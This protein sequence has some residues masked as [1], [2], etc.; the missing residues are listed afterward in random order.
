MLSCGDEP[1]APVQPKVE[2]PR[3]EPV[4]KGSSFSL[5][6]GLTFSELELPPNNRPGGVQPSEWIEVGGPWRYMGT[7]RKGMHKYVAPLPIRPRGLFFHRAE[8][9]LIL[10]DPGGDEVPYGRHG[11]SESPMWSH[12]RTA[13]TVYLPTLSDSP[14]TFS[15]SYPKA[16]A[17]EALLNFEMSGVDDAAAFARAGIQDGWDHRHGLL[18][19]APGVVAFDL[20]LPEA[21]ELVFAP[22]IVLP[23]LLEGARSDGARVVVEVVENGE[24]TVAWQADLRPG[25][26]ETRHVDLSRW[27]GSDVRLRLRSDPGAQGDYDYVFFGDPIVA[28][29][30]DNPRRVVLVFLDTTRPDHLSLYGYKRDTSAALDVLSTRAAVFTN[31]RSVAPWTLPSARTVLTGMNPEHYH[32]TDTLQGTLREEGWATG[33]IAGNVYLSPNFDMQRGWGMHRVSLWPT[34][35]TVVDDA[36]T[37]LEEHDG[38]DTMLQVQFMEAHLP[39]SEPEEYRFKYAGEA[40]DDRLREEFHVSDVRRIQ[41]TQNDFPLMQYVK[42]RY[43]NNL[44]YMTDQVARLVEVLDDDDI[45]VIFGDH[46]EEF[47]DHK[48]FEHGHTV[49]DELLRVPLVID[50]PGIGGTEVHAPTSL[51]DITPTVL[52]LLDLPYDHLE[53]ASLVAAARGDAAALTPLKQRDLPFGRPLYGSERWGLL[54][55]GKKWS[56]TEGREALYD[57]RKDR[58]E[59]DNLLRGDSDDG[60]RIYREGLAAALDREVDV[61]FRFHNSDVKGAVSEDLVAKVVVPGGVRRAWAYADPLEVSR[62]NVEFEEGEEEVLITWPAPFGAQREV[63]I[64]PVEDYVEIT[65]D[66]VVHATQGETEVTF[67]PA[68]RRAAGLIAHRTPLGRARV[69]GRALIMSYGIVPIPEEGTT[70]LS[71]SDAEL[72]EA[73]QAMGYTDH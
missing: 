67:Q 34:A 19:P 11:H 51:L 14:G 73:L 23:E 4:A 69:P 17:R 60:G 31:T 33:M 25:V 16:S 46:G 56:T 70:V 63:Y 58:R 42:D 71:G 24:T 59:K 48:G 66:V 21:A 37:F 49:F 41:M 50:G 30:V 36:I 27:A 5:S 62:A 8:P 43:D 15:L 9:G 32:T 20:S 65:H 26:F 18:V 3:P 57:V 12:D 55:G 13:L 68:K 38:V 53:G 22:G 39:Y 64:Q 7:T 40:P 28:S 29:R 10:K 44:R 61:V 72:A 45:L 47:W 52:D 35:Q 1:N 6:T 2:D 54:S